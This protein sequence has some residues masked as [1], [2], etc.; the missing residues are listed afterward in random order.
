MLY[1][2][3]ASDSILTLEGD[4]RGDNWFLALFRLV[5]SLY[6]AGTLIAP[7]VFQRPPIWLCSEI[8]LPMILITWLLYIRFPILHNVMRFPPLQIALRLN[9]IVYETH[10]ISAFIDNAAKQQL[11]LFSLVLVGATG[12]FGG[13]FLPMDRSG[14]NFMCLK[15][16][17]NDVTSSTSFCVYVSII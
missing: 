2:L 10:S 6:G 7:V 8:I 16:D 15:Y 11:P 1:I 14:I 12:G 9:H 5:T 13:I 3:K 17:C 4:Y